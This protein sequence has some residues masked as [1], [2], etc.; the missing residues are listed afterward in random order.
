MEMKCKKIFPTV[1]YME[2]YA[3]VKHNDQYSSLT[4]K[5]IY[6]LVIEKLINIITSI[7]VKWF[8]MERKVHC[9]QVAKRWRF[10]KQQFQAMWSDD[11]AK[12]ESQAVN[13]QKNILPSISLRIP[14]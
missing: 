9:V 5:S 14:K 10:D 1:D 12:W 11:F 3:T 8:C 2:N 13:L 7:T 6:S 4:K